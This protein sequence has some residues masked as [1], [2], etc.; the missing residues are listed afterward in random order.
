MNHQSRSEIPERY[1]SL[2]EPVQIGPL[3]APNR[4]YAVPHATGHG[5][6]QPHGSIA[7]RA[8]KAEGGWGTVAVQ[9][10]E[11]ASDSDM[12]SHPMDR[13]W[14][15]AD[16]DQHRAQVDA[17]HR[18]G[19]L[20]AI[21]L[22]HGGMRARNFTTGQ[23]I[24][25][26]GN[27]A[28]LRPEVPLQCRAMRPDDIRHFRDSHKRAAR[29]ACEAGYDILYVYAA[30]DLSLLSHFLSIRTNHRTDHYG[31]SLENRMRLLREV[32]EDTLEV[33]AG[34][35]AVALRFSVAEPG[36][37][38][39]LRHDGEGRDVVE[40]LAELPDLWDVNLSGWSEDSATARFAEEGFQLL[41]TDFV[42]SLTSKPV[43][44]VGRFTSADLMVSLVKNRRLDLIGAARPSIADPFLPAKIREGRV[45]DIRECIGCNIC[46]SMDSY[47]VPIRC[48]QNPTISEEWRRGWHPENPVKT[49]VHTRTADKPHHLI[50]GAGPAGLEC[51]YTLMQAG[52]R[53]TVA[54]RESE[55]GGRLL[56]EARLPGLSSWLRVR[57]FRL[58]KLL[59]SA[60]ANL[61]LSSNMTADDVIEFGADSV[62]VAT[63]SLWCISGAGSTHPGQR[64]GL[65]KNFHQL[66]NP[67][68]IMKWL[69]DETLLNVNIQAGRSKFVVYDDEHFYMASVI[70]EALASKGADVVYATPLPCI[71]SWTD[72]TLDLEKII[73]RLNELKVAL[74]P[75]CSLTEN[76]SFVSTLNAEEI[77]FADTDDNPSTKR[78]LVIAGIRKPVVELHDALLEKWAAK[79][80][81]PTLFAAGDCKVPGLIQSAVYSGHTTAR[82]I[83][84]PSVDMSAIRREHIVIA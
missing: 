42:K 64:H 23:Q 25:G 61:Y 51:A 33:A 17:I 26:P 34:K 47:G 73:E 83:L 21:E 72:N 79:Q 38:I 32:L 18:H 77:V 8:M 14:D 1:A 49:V 41:Y 7:L 84:D 56:C 24:A 19:A 30:H 6:N 66:L 68:D 62:T 55:A 13:I 71:A 57:D 40:A 69:Q 50:V 70:A 10:C 65:N 63:G 35:K 67:D 15:D 52:H 22:A 29:R 5:W 43:V 20:A 74:H 37:A 2:F 76:G 4:F 44:G 78:S 46:V 36:Q 59:Q 27:M 82:Q 60:S 31:G 28:I 39:G 54:E 48:T 11:I 16:I 81:R 3:V 75:N 58:S 45:E 12:A 9:M 80:S 53:V